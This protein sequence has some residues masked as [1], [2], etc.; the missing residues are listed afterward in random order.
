MRKVETKTHIQFL[1]AECEFYYGALG[2]ICASRVSVQAARRPVKD[3]SMPNLRLIAVALL[4]AFI[5]TACT[6]PSDAILTPSG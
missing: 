3:K 6:T 5:L 2:S 1:R 4:L